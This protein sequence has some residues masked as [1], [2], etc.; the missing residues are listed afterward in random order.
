[1]LLADFTARWDRGENPRAEDYLH[2]IWPDH[3]SAL[4]EL[5]YCEYLR[6]EAAGLDPEP[7]D[8]FARFPDLSTRLERLFGLHDA[9]TSS[10]LRVWAEPPSG[11]EPLP[12]EG[13][14]IGPYRLLRELGRGGFARVFLAEQADLAD[15]LVVVKVSTR[16][17]PEPRLLARSSHPHIVEVLWHGVVSDGSLQVICM[18][19][20]GGAPLSAL[21]TADRKRGTR[22]VSGRGLLADLDR[23]SEAGYPAPSGSRPARELIAGLTY[24]KA[25]AWIIA[26]LAEALDFAYGRGVLHGDIKPSN[27]LLTADG[28]PMLL[29]FNLAIHWRPYVYGPGAREVPG[30]Q[31]GTL[32]YMAP[33]R[34]R[35]VADLAFAPR[36]SAAD[37]HRADIYA[38]GVVLLEAL[39]ARTPELKAGPGLSL[40]QMAS[41]YI[42]SREQG[43]ETMIRSARA[44]IPAA[45]R[46][47]VE[48]CLAPDPADRYKRASELADDLD[49]WREDR[50]LAFARE[51]ST[52][53]AV[54]RWS[55][56]QR[57]AVAAGLVGL[58]FAVGSTALVSHSLSTER[59]ARAKAG[60]SQIGTSEES[61]AFLLR[62]PVSLLVKTKTDPAELAKRYLERY[63]V[64]GTGEWRERDDYRDL[65]AFER[66]ELEV[67]LM[68]QALRFAHALGERPDSP[69][70][71][72]RALYCIER[73]DPS[74]RY[75][76]IADQGRALRT[77]LGLA[78]LDTGDGDGTTRAPATARWM[79]DYLAAV[80]LELEGR[81]NEAL[82]LYLAVRKVR[83]S[84]FW[85]NY[86][87]AAVAF[88]LRRYSSATEYLDTCVRLRPD[89]PILRNQYAGC[90]YWSGMF[91]EALK[92]CDVAQKLD[93]DHP[94]TFLSRSF[95]RLKLGQAESVLRDVNRFEMLTGR[96]RLPSNPPR[97]LDL[98]GST[99]PEFHGAAASGPGKMVADSDEIYVRSEL[100]MWLW[101]A[102]EYETALEE[103]NRVLDADPLLLPARYGRASLLRLL[104]RAGADRDYAF[105]VEHPNPEPLLNEHP[106]AFFAFYRHA[107]SLIEQG[108]A[109]EALATAEKTVAIADRLGKRQAE[110]H[111]VLA[112]ALYEVARRGETGR[113]QVAH[114]EVDFA[115]LLEPDLIKRWSNVPFVND[116]R[117]RF[118][119]FAF[120]E[121]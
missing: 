62:R 91:D 60:Y 121:P 105:V 48:H 119:P 71:W 107:S 16:V 22:P 9:I 10:Q 12:D 67:W 7:D 120:E 8:Y 93:P 32:A 47:I 34:L 41:A 84:S 77:L 92:E 90:L 31:G 96:N 112:R 117:M 40:Q 66:A 106:A 26:R 46:S 116:L 39:T 109:D 11:T 49:R 38:L 110:T 54:V 50:P 24:P 15:R 58:A 79:Q 99:S 52:L 118:G 18:P 43:G 30:D 27:V 72:R 28:S 73:A 61:G 42:S 44:P 102:G 45:L 25:M 4:V 78:D 81:E 75:A 108:K 6:A 104:N 1:M 29:D 59:H 68:E 23:V 2:R 55:R 35:T 63:G 98:I 69:E 21:L 64:L 113:F 20:L 51:P 3:P 114:E 101:R 14:E 115:C 100:A 85:A 56:R 103:F 37:R 5:V 89:N 76:P 33:E 97:P 19:F 95:I 17:T 74:Q 83:P 86:R 111:L 57:V 13:D 82:S 88:V 53:A 94:E 70:D 36:A 87:A 65:P 80:R